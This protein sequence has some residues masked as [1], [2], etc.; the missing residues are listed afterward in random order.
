[1]LAPFTQHKYRPIVLGAQLWKF[2]WRWSVWNYTCQID[3]VTV[4]EFCDR[5]V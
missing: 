3:A 2:K 1:M 5:H 4:T